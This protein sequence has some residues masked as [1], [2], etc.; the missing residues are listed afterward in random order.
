MTLVRKSE[1]KGEGD[2]F[3]SIK[4]QGL[5]HTMRVMSAGSNYTPVLIQIS[6]GTEEIS[7]LLDEEDVDALHEF[8]SHYISTRSSK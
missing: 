6:R 7:A 5:I 2:D 8:L 4:M 1:P 3:R